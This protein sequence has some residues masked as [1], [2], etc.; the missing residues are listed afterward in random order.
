M[1][2][3]CRHASER[4]VTSGATVTRA[5]GESHLMFATALLSL[6]IPLLSA[7]VA[8][9]EAAASPQGDVAAALAEWLALCQR[10]DPTLLRGWYEQHLGEPGARRVPVELRAQDDASLCAATRGYRP[11]GAIADEL[12]PASVDLVGVDLPLWMHLSYAATGARFERFDL[13]P[14]PPPEASLPKNLTDR[15]LAR[16]VAD[17]VT[18]L[19]AR[20]LFS[21]IVVVARGSQPIAV[22]SAGYADRART[23]PFSVTTR[24]TLGSLG[25]LFTAVAIV[26]LADQRKLSLDDPVRRFYPDYP[27][28]VIR[29]RAT[30]A[31]L[32]S[33]TAG[34]GD[35]LG[36]RTARMM[37]QG[38]RR[39][40]EF[41]PLYDHDA[42]L[43]PP[44][45]GWSYSN[46]GFALAGAI[47]E[48]ASHENYPDYLRRHVFAVAG[49]TRSDP[50]NV[51][52]RP[53]DLVTPYTRMTPHGPGGTWQ[54]ADPDIGSPAGGAV[55][56]A[57]DLVKFA[58]AL[59]SGRLVSRAMFQDMAT[60][61]GTTPWHSHYGYGVEIEDV[62]GRVLVG[63]GGG[64]PG[65]STHLHLLVGTHYSI[66]VLSNQDPPAEAYAGSRVVA[67]VVARE[68]A[69]R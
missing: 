3:G 4:T 61:H 19:G 39:A 36:R 13:R 2:G 28:A 64:F 5:R 17:W 54:V 57:S 23:S 45:T 66:V 52:I 41:L 32:L 42:P 38:T 35:F 56:S 15:A 31:M 65:V 20:G 8:V 11:G 7:Q 62:N 30:I 55:S 47:V 16:E 51:P 40:D 68:R 18:K 25:K 69:R 33:H 9:A 63:H 10:A 58:D 37:S 67:L 26:Q 29:E 49:M 6:A 44:G 34:L 12:G 60:A 22:A 50:N 27:D 14:R 46:A 48:Q 24:F 1:A 59:V 43:F 21:G 53:A